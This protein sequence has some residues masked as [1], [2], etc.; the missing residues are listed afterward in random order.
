MRKPR[1]SL[2]WLTPLLLAGGCAMAKADNRR[3]LN[4]LDAHATPSSTGARWAM[5]PIALPTGIVALAADAVIVH[6][7]C[8]IDDASI[9]VY[10]WLWTNEGETDLRRWAMAPVRAVVSPFA[11]AVSWTGRALFAISP[12]E[13]DDEPPP[14]TANAKPK[15]EGKAP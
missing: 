6:P 14:T 13:S 10:E 2:L 9:D 7:C 5:A 11:F 1:A 3:T 15:Q 8:V 12:H 4:W